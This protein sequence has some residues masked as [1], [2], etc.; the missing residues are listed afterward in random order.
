MSMA[1]GGGWTG[2][3]KN[4]PK[5][6]TSLTARTMRQ[7]GLML[8]VAGAVIAAG[9][10]AVLPRALSHGTTVHGR[11][12]RLRPSYQAPDP[13]AAARNQAAAWIATWV[14]DTAIVSCDP[15]M[16]GVL[17]AHGM[18]SRLQPINYASSDPLG[19]EVL[20]A[21][22]VI[23]AQFGSR[24]SSVYAPV[25]LARFGSGTDEIDVRV[26]PPFGAAAYLTQFRADAQA[27]R[28][29]GRELLHNSRITETSSAA[30]LLAAGSVDSRLLLTFAALAH[31]YSFEILGFGGDGHGANPGVPF[32]SAAITAGPPAPTTDTAIPGSAQ[33]AA[34]KTLT[35]IVTYLKAQRTPL[36][37]ASVHE[38]R[39]RRGPI[40]VQIDFA[41]PSLL[42]LLGTTPVSA[43]P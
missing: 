16:C 8:A 25:V 43:Q 41:A 14:S 12:R 33:T 27:R 23:R 28:S 6:A 1:D 22:A 37:P 30:E 4:Y 29:A 2:D 5:H 38:L 11:H 39:P 18:G 42:G 21:T 36:R 15:Q 10:V 7:R 32:L 24:L 9:V 13:A 17:T 3:P 34:N 19:S 26:V 20:A 35:G 40:I 31:A